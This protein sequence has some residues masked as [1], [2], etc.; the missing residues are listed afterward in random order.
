[1]EKWVTEEGFKVGEKAGEE[2]RQIGGGWKSTSHER[3]KK[4]DKKKKK[5]I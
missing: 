5:Y 1:M 3:R 2:T 4:S